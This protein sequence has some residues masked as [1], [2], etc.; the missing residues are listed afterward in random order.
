MQS[1]YV[2][3]VETS[4]LKKFKETL[5]ICQQELGK[6]IFF[7]PRI[8]D[9]IKSFVKDL[10]DIRSSSSL[11]LNFRIMGFTEFPVHL[12]NI[13]IKFMYFSY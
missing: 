7:P 2:I 4:R 10:E 13:L 11:H 1:R 12:Q 9:S 6:T 5:V 8:D 3:Y